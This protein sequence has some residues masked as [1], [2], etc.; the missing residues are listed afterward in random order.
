MDYRKLGRTGLKVSALCLGTMQWGWTASEGQ[1]WA[2]M[3]A[4]VESGGNFLDTADMYSRWVPGNGG[5]VSEEIIGR[6][7]HERKNRD[8]LVLATKVRQPMGAGPNDQ[9]LS[10]KHIMDAVDASLRRLR[11]DY[12]DLY[13][14]HAYDDD[15]PI[16]ETLR[17]FE[18]LR[19]AGKVR[20]VG[21]SNYTAWR[22]IEA[23][24]ASD[25][26][27]LVRYDSL[28]PHYNIVHRAEFEQDLRLICERYQIGV[29]PY[30]SLANGFLTGKYRRDE[31]VESQR[32][33]SIQRKYATET[34]WRTLD[35]LRDVALETGSSPAAVALA[36]L[37]AQPAVT[38]PILGANTPEQL[39]PGLQ[40]PEIKLSA[41]HLARLDRA[42]SWKEE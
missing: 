10:R 4:F 1:A 7:M 26:H 23:L 35:T 14:A 5:G 2:V 3:D 18:D 36:W 16:E 8:R 17:A 6:W 40:G 13:Q 21:A 11:T 34:A 41:K 39:E 42:S 28:Q 25:V 33:E 30:S 32:A 31:F 37:L 20:Y 9:G 38:A 19:R 29:I 22:L 24:W 12:I 27:N 15:T